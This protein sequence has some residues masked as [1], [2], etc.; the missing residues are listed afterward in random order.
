MGQI[1]AS[2]HGGFSHSQSHVLLVIV[3]VL[4]QGFYAILENP[5]PP[6]N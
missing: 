2:E 1:I 3:R 4:D 6:T 5:R